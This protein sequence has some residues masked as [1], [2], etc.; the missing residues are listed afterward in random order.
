MMHLKSFQQFEHIAICYDEPMGNRKH[1]SV[2]RVVD[3]IELAKRRKKA[4]RLYQVGESQYSIANELHVSYAAVCH[5]VE[6]YKQYGMEGLKS[7]G[8]PGPKPLS[9]EHAG[10]TISAHVSAK[11]KSTTQKKS[12]AP[13]SRAWTRLFNVIGKL[14]PN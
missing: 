13:S 11:S 14:H 9:G 6:A 4:I 7:L 3:R 8:R 1:P 12:T 2:R 5:W 10:K